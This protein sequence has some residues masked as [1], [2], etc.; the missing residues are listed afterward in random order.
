MLASFQKV[1]GETKGQDRQRQLVEVIEVDEGKREKEK[2]D[3]RPDQ[4]TKAGL[5]LEP[6]EQ[7]EG[8]DPERQEQRL[9]DEQGLGM[10]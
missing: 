7:V 9:D 4:S 1:D 8:Q 10:G 2:V 5:Q 3:R 6:G